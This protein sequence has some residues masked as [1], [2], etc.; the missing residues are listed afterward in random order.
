MNGV[1]FGTNENSRFGLNDQEVTIETG[2]QCTYI[3]SDYYEMVFERVLE[4]S[5]GY[6]FTSDGETVVDCGD[7]Q[8]MRALS[9]LVNDMWVEVSPIDYLNPI[10]ATFNSIETNTGQCRVCLKQSSD[11]YWHLGTSAL[12]GYYS[13]FDF[14][15][16]QISLTPLAA[17]D[18]VEVVSSSK[19]DRILGLNLVTVTAIAIGMGTILAI[20]TLLILAVCFNIGP[21]NT[22]GAKQSKAV[23]APAKLSL[24]ELEVLLTKALMKKQNLA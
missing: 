24:D 7:K 9:L 8:N 12:V 11:T 14:T 10:R 16:R 4:Y 5:T 18:K 20:F 13:K 2:S 3:P 17:A 23:I 22:N 19:P 21:F 1:W 15:N 6:Y